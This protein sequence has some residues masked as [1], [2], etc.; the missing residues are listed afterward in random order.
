MV[1][2]LLG[3]SGGDINAS[4]LGLKYLNYLDLSFNDFRGIRDPGVHQFNTG[5]Q[6]PQPLKCWFQWDDTSAAWESLK[7]TYLDLNSFYSLHTLYAD[8][9]EWL[10][11]LSSLQYLDMNSVNLS[12]THD[13]F[14]AINV[15]PSLSVLRPV[16]L[17]PNWLFNMS[18]LEYLNLQFN[19]FHGSIPDAFANMTSLEVM[20]LAKNRLIGPLTNSVGKLC[21]LRTLDLSSN[22]ISDDVSALAIISSGCAAKSLEILNLRGN[23]LI[24]CLGGLTSIAV[25]ALGNNN[26][27]GNIP[28][29]IG[30]LIWLQALHLGNNSI[31]GTL[32]Q[33]LK[34][35]TRLETLD[36]GENRLAG[37]IPTWIGESL[38]NLRILRL[39]SNMFHG[40]IPPQISLLTSLQILD[41]AD[42]GLSGIIP[43]GLGD[44]TAM[45]LTHKPKERMLDT[46]QSVVQASLNNYGPSGFVESLLLFVGKI[47][48]GSQLQTF[49]DPSM[50]IGN[51]GLCGP[52]LDEEC[53]GS[54][55]NHGA[56]P[57]CGDED[58]EFEEDE[59]EITGDDGDED[60]DK[61]STKLWLGFFD[62]ECKCRGGADS[63]ERP[64]SHKEFHPLIF[65]FWDE[66]PARVEK[67]NH[68]K[69]IDELWDDY[70]FAMY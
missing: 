68:E 31:N 3:A 24:G 36:V 35:C 6:L 22:N 2:A 10:S 28:S 27:S 49:R 45:A 58:H 20:Q 11:H 70:N 55:T 25:I 61:R 19:Q 59:E 44:I 18:N 42:N 50:Y 54:E 13:W 17:L 5:P 40:F 32:P 69:T 7:F 12:N 56:S 16:K 30:T 41:L 43:H 51:P 15:L 64:S 21:N 26:L 66:V 29:S 46:L 57:S 52:P 8:D 38:P 65:S 39:R 48:S 47:P 34:S 60:E 23:T 67:S 9:L 14:R 63:Y 1:L 4:L 62:N 33:E 37:E 53:K